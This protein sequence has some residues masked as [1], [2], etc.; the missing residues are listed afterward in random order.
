MTTKSLVVPRSVFNAYHCSRNEARVCMTRG[1]QFDQL[2]SNQFRTDNSSFI[3]QMFPKKVCN[4][5]RNIRWQGITQRYTSRAY[6]AITISKSSFKRCK[7]DITGIKLLHISQIWR[8][9]FKQGSKQTQITIS[10]DLI[11]DDAAMLPVSKR[12]LGDKSID[13]LSG[14]G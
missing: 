14:Y 2:R 12:S 7:W 3:P 9:G 10:F 4:W 8:L 1:D 6:S 5:K 11:F 13:Q